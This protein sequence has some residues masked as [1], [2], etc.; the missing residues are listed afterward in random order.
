MQSERVLYA[1]IQQFSF[2]EA[3]LENE[4][5]FEEC[6]AFQSGSTGFNTGKGEKQ[7]NSHAACLGGWLCLAAM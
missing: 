5:G 2:S 3:I 1:E 7:N 6:D 4:S